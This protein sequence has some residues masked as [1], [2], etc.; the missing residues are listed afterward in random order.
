[1]QPL[2]VSQGKHPHRFRIGPPPRIEDHRQVDGLVFFVELG[3]DR[4]LVGGLDRFRHIHR[5]EAELHQPFRLQPDDHPGSAG[6]R[7]D[8]QI[9]RAP[10]AAQDL[11]DLPR[12]LI[13]QI[14]ILPKNADH[15]RC[16]LAR[17]RFPDAIGQEGQNL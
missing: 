7:F 8:L 2:A 14:Q 16:G 6:R 9:S 4:P 10:H 17:Q 11:A 15:H 1:M 12:D 13:E 5:A 3:G